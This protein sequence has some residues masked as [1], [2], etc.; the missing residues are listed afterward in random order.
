MESNLN[1]AETTMPAPPVSLTI[2][3]QQRMIVPK[4]E[5]LDTVAG[6]LQ[7]IRR[8]A[9]RTK[10]RHTKVEGRGRRIRMP[11]ACAA[12]IFQLTRELGHKSDGETVRWLLHHAEP[13]IVAATGTGTVPAI[14]TNV[15]GTLKIPTH[16]PSASAPST[17]SADDE[18]VVKKRRK[19]QPSRALGGVGVGSMMAPIG[20]GQGMVPMWP[21]AVWMIPP[22]AAAQPG[23][24]L[25][26]MIPPS[27]LS[28]MRPVFSGA[29]QAAPAA[30][31]PINSSV[32][33]PA[34]LQLMGESGA[35]EEEEQEDE[36]DGEDEEEER[37]ADSSEN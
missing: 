15:G 27:G 12:R 5:P 17:S 37:I 35:N 2:H 36:D 19:L 14:A 10:D 21:Q 20:A 4:P 28:G 30:P 23:Q 9:G 8:P 13:A 3:Q 32:A 24:D 25:V 6:G 29:M 7:I 22:A 34:P 18:A 1:E 33:A 26:W 11:A 31:V 16:A